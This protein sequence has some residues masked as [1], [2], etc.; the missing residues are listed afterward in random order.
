MQ[1]ATTTPFA[2][3]LPPSDLRQGAAVVGLQPNVVVTIAATAPAGDAVTVFY[4]L[5]DVS[6]RDRLV[7]PADLAGLSLATTERPWSFDGDGE[8]FQLACEARL[9]DLA[10]LYDPMMA[11]HASTVQPL[12]R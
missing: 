11:V 10:F 7:T 3:M 8:A 1:A 5:P 2:P 4:R 9:I 6:T 12:P